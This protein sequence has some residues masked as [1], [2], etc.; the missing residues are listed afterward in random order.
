MIDLIILSKASTDSEYEM[1]KR[2]IQTVNDS[3]VNIIVME[4][5]ER[6]YDVQTVHSPGDFNYNGF[7]NKGA[8]LG[9]SEWIMV[10]NNDIIFHANWLDPLLEAQSPLVSPHEPTDRRQRGLMS[11]E[12]GDIVGRHLSGWCFMIK[13]TLWEQIGGFDED[14]EF[15]CSDN[16]VVE[17]VKKLGILPTVVARSLVTHIGSQTLQTAPDADSLKW[18]SVYIYNKKYGKDLFVGNANYLIWLGNN[19]E[20]VSGL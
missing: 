7:A 9:N 10:A 6:T 5:T 1:T 3:R 17:Q 20:L 11:N 16:V 12:T 19:K 15:W 13:R 4:Q 8:S 18:K 14:V 2:A